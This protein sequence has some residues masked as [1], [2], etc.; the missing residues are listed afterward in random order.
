MQSGN[1]Q[2]VAARRYV[3]LGSPAL[4]Y[5][6]WEAFDFWTPTGTYVFFTV[7]CYMGMAF[8]IRA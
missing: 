2:D 8:R 7:P 5:D 1:A 4:L 3:Q 6:T